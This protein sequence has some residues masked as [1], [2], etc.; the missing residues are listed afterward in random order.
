MK[1]VR[2]LLILHILIFAFPAAVLSNETE[3]A[4]KEAIEE[5]REEMRN[6][7][8]FGMKILKKEIAEKK[9]NLKHLKSQL[10]DL[11]PDRIPMHKYKIQLLEQDLKNYKNHMFILTK[12]QM[13]GTFLTYDADTDT[14]SRIP[15]ARTSFSPQL[16][17]WRCSI[18]DEE[19]REVVES[20]RE[21]RE[22]KKAYEN[23]LNEL[24][25]TKPK[26]FTSL[27][28]AKE[29]DRKKE[30]I[31]AEY[32]EYL[33]KIRNVNEGGIDRR[34]FIGKTKA[35]PIERKVTDITNKNPD[36]NQEMQY[37]K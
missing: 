15:I 7:K 18:S 2:V 9:Q 21:E 3:Q 26:V 5:A 6:P 36:Q 30:A 4:T 1:P 28:E 31:T 32:A 25:R 16:L 34:D 37:W 20:Q 19:Y 29:Y 10:D 17:L 13:R 27:E 14:Y 33:K 12:C 24:I 22:M 8:P 35:T 11:P 23:K